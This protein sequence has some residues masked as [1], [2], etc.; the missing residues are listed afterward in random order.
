MCKRVLSERGQVYTGYKVYLLGMSRN[1][2]N[3]TSTSRAF[4]NML[5]GESLRCW[6]VWVYGTE[7]KLSGKV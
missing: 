5:E 1:S 2:M 7:T 6:G 4:D 3:A